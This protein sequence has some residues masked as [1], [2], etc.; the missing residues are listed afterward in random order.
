MLQHDKCT[1]MNCKPAI[2]ETF[3]R[4]LPRFQLCDYVLGLLVGMLVFSIWG[5]CLP[6]GGDKIQE[7]G[8]DFLQFYTAGLVA[9][10]GEIDRLY[11][12]PHFRELQRFE[13][14][15]GVCSLYPPMMAAM[16]KP[17]ARLP[18]NRALAVWWTIQAVCFAASGWLLYRM[19]PLA[20]Q[21]R[22]IALVAL[23][24]LFPVWIA[25]RIGHLSPLLLLVLVGGIT[26]HRR[27]N[28]AWAGL[29]LSL[30]AIKPQF[31][32]GLFAWLVLRRDF[33]ATVGMVAGGMG[34]FLA[35]SALL[36]P[37]VFFD[38]LH[39]MPTI[40][41]IVRLYRYSPIF[42]QSLGGIVDNQL[43]SHGVGHGV[44]TAA[45]LLTHVVTASLAVILLCRLVWAN[46]QGHT[47]TG[48]FS[49]PEGPKMSQ[50]PG[51]EM[52]QSPGR[53][54]SQPPAAC[55]DYEYACAVLFMLLF[56]PYLLVYDLTLLALPLA[57][58]WSTPGWKVGVTLYA[59]MTVA[60]AAL[61]LWI[62]FSVT[63]LTALWAL[64]ESYI[65]VEKGAAP[66]LTAVKS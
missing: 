36:G 9:Q 50:S 51:R 30:M 55:Q 31:A 11:D 57:L 54:M 22:I 5:G 3:R 27:G 18:Y 24:G 60:C 8:G 6:K 23:A 17:L 13:V 29:V 64:F 26:L 37:R 56:P 12:H 62:S 58:L 63:A 20:R 32:L 52:S 16:M 45:M 53:E 39:A 38:Y 7:H 47:G 21:W 33:R 43:W 34:Q 61:C 4:H 65:A 40:T 25:I 19:M 49:R 48:T 44:R 35:V 41:V 59:T 2:L 1:S 10:R 42:E 15:D 14:D 46:R 66:R 28:P